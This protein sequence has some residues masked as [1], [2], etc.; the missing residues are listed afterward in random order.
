MEGIAGIVYPDVFQTNSHVNVMLDTMRHRGKNGRE[1][2][3]YKNIQLG[4]CGAKMGVNDKQTVYACLDGSIYNG[5]NIKE[6][7]KK[8]GLPINPQSSQSDLIVK[9]YELWGTGCFAHLSGDFAIAIFDQQKERLLLARDRIGKKPLYWYQD[10]HYF[11]FASELKALLATGS[12]PQTPSIEALS[13]YL[14]FGYIP[15]DMTPI[16]DANKLLPGHFLQFNK[17]RSMIIQSFWS[18]SSFFEN[19]PALRKSLFI[20]T[21]DEMMQRA[22]KIRMPKNDSLKKESIGCLVSGGLGSATIAH[23]M[24]KSGSSENIQAFSVGFKDQNESDVL[25]A[26][27]VTKT[28]NIPQEVDLITPNSFLSNLVKIAWH[29]DEPSADPNVVAIWKLASLASQKT[30]I[31]FSGMGSDEL[32]AGHSRYSLAETN[33]P[34]FR[35]T[36]HPAL[37]LMR[38]YM[39]PILNFFYEP[40]AYNMLKQ[41][42]TNPWQFGYL[43]HNALFD[44]KKLAA[45]SPR[46]AGIFNPEVFLHK[47]H[48]LSRIK[49]NV[50]AFLYFDVKTRL[51]DS[52]ILQVERLT[53]A[54]SLEWHAPFLDRRIVEFVAGHP[55]IEMINEKETGVILKD[56]LKEVYP[57]QI[58][59]RPKRTRKNFLQ[60]WVNVS[61][62]SDLFKML[63]RGTL[64]ETGLISE[65]WLKQQ[66]ETPEKQEEGFHHLWALLM[67]EIWFKLFIN[68]Q[69]STSCPDVSVKELL[70]EK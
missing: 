13:S 66:L 17:N 19:K 9:A 39:I 25:T 62:L 29:L 57:E 5:D 69:T 28:L 45:A 53:A 18:Y 40:L 11:I 61:E 51:A 54:H 12:V 48:N 24:K 15:Q 36:T 10:N 23:Y 34:F 21:L 38:R 7:L 30:P 64:V 4:I 70:S 32:L 60:S 46:L 37:A 33:M 68:R 49:S 26:S 42:R 67:L 20:N 1:I 8:H 44:E 3:S 65:G 56:L 47:F 41:S 22:V 50:S 59:C 58:L 52:F 43:K 2:N 16:K 31:V 63:T 55:E 35:R 6:E 14:F 27:E